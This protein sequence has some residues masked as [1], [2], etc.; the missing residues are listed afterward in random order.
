VCRS[1]S[2]ARRRCRL[3]CS[4]PT[5]CA[6]GR[7]PARGRPAAVH[8]CAGRGAGAESHGHGRD[9]RTAARRAVV[10]GRQGSGTYVTASPPARSDAP[11]SAR[12]SGTRRAPDSPG[13]RGRLL[14][15]ESSTRAQRERLARGGPTRGQRGPDSRA[16]RARLAGAKVDLRAGRPCVEVLDGAAWR[17]AWRVA[18]DGPPDLEPEPRLRSGGRRRA[19]AA[20]PRAAGR[21]G[22]GAGHHGQYVG[23][24]A[25]GPGPVAGSAGGR[26]GAGVPARAVGA[27]RPTDGCGAGRPGGRARGGHLAD[28]ATERAVVAAAAERGVLLDGLARHFVGSPSVAG[29]VLGYAGPPRERSWSAR[30]RSSRP[31]CGHAAT[32]VGAGPGVRYRALPRSSNAP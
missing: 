8:A 6:R 7:G 12:E 19:P 25:V 1:S 9:L 16:T 21:P 28:G 27:G 4:S 22:R 17:R 29:I 13:A 31:R 18:A 2:T 3:P 32:V 23:A 30:S 20:S 14:R 24:R 15:N 5:G 10:T 11:A 26:G